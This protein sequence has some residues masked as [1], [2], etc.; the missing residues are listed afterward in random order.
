MN[1]LTKLLPIPTKTSVHGAI[2]A[3]IKK[4]RKVD[5]GEQEDE[6]SGKEANFY[7]PGLTPLL[8]LRWK[9]E[10]CHRSSK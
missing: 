5:G 7:F 4:D 6:E 3:G 10:S 8:S 9:K 2:K 1:K